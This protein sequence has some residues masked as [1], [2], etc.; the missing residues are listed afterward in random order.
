M[1]ATRRQF[2]ASSVAAAAFAVLPLSPALAQ[3][4]NGLFDDI[5]LKDRILGDVNAPVTIVEYASMTCPHCKSF[6]EKILPEIK[7]KYIDTGKAKLIMRPFPFDGDRRG[8]A[9]FMLALCAP[10]DAYYPMVDAIFAM[11]DK[12]RTSPTVVDDLRQVSKMAGMTEDQFTK[13]LSGG[14]PEL[15]SQMIQGRNRA[16]RDFKVSA[17]PTIFVNNQKLGDS[18]LETISEAIE[19]A[20]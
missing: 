20:L 2:L 19:A 11:Q 14:E 5:P 15:Y 7:T 6:H 18:R 8:E 9:G 3:T 13:C 4:I 16:V 10:N 12:L 17:T 1:I